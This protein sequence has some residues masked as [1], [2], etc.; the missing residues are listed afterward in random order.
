[1]RQPSV[2]TAMLALAALSA[3][4]HAPRRDVKEPQTAKSAQAT[5][6]KVITND[7]LCSQF[8]GG[9]ATG[10]HETQK[11]N[12]QDDA[13]LSRIA[14]RWRLDYFRRGNT[15]W[16]P[17]H[18]SSRPKTETDY[19]I[20]SKTVLV[21]SVPEFRPPFITERYKFGSVSR[22]SETLVDVQFA[23]VSAT[24]AVG[25]TQTARFKLSADGKQLEIT[26]DPDDPEPTVEVLTLIDA[27]WSAPVGHDK[28]PQ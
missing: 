24:C 14:G 18:D 15:S 6:A 2:I 22:V 10:S 3:A 7:N 1:M 17:G 19:L 13:F 27:N 5:K 26:K 23:K 9:T 4:A 16:W 11:H 21:Q 20:G 8:A 28:T 25:D 12:A